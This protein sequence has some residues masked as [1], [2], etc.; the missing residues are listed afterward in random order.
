MNQSKALLMPVS[1]FHNN[2]R[3]TADSQGINES[4]YKLGPNYDQSKM[5]GTEGG[6]M[7]NK[8]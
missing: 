8:S 2:M 1:S 4:V 7:H 6:Q 3:A 5:N